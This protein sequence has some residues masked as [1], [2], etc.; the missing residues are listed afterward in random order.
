MRNDV[1]NEMDLKQDNNY[2]HDSVYFIEKQEIA[3]EFDLIKKTFCNE[4]STIF[5]GK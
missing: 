2:K 3:K 1:G 4:I 5:V